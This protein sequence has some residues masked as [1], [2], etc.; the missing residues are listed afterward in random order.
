MVADALFDA[1]V[2]LEREL[3]WKNYK[4]WDYLPRLLLLIEEMKELGSDLFSHPD[5]RKECRAW[6]GAK[7]AGDLAQMAA[8]EAVLD[9]QR[10]E[11]EAEAQA[12][13]KALEA[14]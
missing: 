13:A 2:R 14:N 11:G 12:Q 5:I 7:K 3:V 9:Q 10:A 8:I 4:N 6:R 1:V